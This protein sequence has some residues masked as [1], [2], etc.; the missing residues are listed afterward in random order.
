MFQQV[1]AQACGSG[2]EEWGVRKVWV[3]LARV[4]SPRHTVVVALPLSYPL[5]CALYQDTV[6]SYRNLIKSRFRALFSLAN[7]DKNGRRARVEERGD[8]SIFLEG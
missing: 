3:K 8:S 6:Y 5:L 2:H 1:T 7:L 4:Q